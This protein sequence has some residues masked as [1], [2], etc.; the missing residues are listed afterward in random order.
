VIQLDQRVWFDL[1]KERGGGSRT[2]L[3]KKEFM[4]R[5]VFFE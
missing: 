1:I 3:N 4:Q 5:L 2:A